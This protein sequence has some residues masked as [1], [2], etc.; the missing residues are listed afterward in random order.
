MIKETKP[1]VIDGKTTYHV[2]AHLE[3]IRKVGSG[4]YGTVA[5]FR[6]PSSGMP[7][8]CSRFDVIRGEIRSEESAKCV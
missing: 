1:V 3:F 2:P 6:D 8:P 4:A 7:N 5:S